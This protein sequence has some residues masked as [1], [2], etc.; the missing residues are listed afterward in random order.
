VR[1]ARQLPAGGDRDSLRHADADGQ[2]S[3]CGGSGLRDRD[4]RAEWSRAGGDGFGNS[5]L[6]F[7][8]Q[9][10]QT[11]SASQQVTLN[12][13]GS[14]ALTI[15]NINCVGN[16]FFSVRLSESVRIKPGGRSELHDRGE[17]YACECRRNGSHAHDH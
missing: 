16:E 9:Q 14:A 3:E 12:N 2:Q 1:F 15:T 10:A 6:A 5:M 17:L 7:G 4:D 11:V 8:P 13:T